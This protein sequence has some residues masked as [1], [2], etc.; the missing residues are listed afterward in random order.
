MKVLTVIGARP[1]IIKA[2]SLSREISLTPG[3]EEIIVHTGQ[4][5][6]K[7][8]SHIFF[9]QMQI[10][11]PNYNL[12]INGLSHGAMTGRMM[13]KIEELLLNDRPD[14]VVVFGDTNST[15]AGALAASKLHIPVAHV[16]AGIRSFNK[17]MPEEINRICTDHCSTILFSPNLQGIENLKAEGLYD[18]E[19][20]ILTGDIMY[21]SSMHFLNYSQ[22]PAQ[23]L[24]KKY[25][26]ATI[27]R[28][29]NTDG[30]NKLKEIIDG[31]N[32]INKDI[33]IV[34]P[35]HP[36]TEKLIIHSGIKVE[37]QTMEPVG[38]LEMIHLLKN[39]SMVVTD[40]GGLQKEAYFFKKPCVTV[41]DQTEWVEL[42]EHGA[43]I[44]ADAKAAEIKEKA[45]S[46]L[47]KEIN[48]D[49]ELYG[50]GHS[51]RKIVAALL[52]LEK[53]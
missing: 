50:D 1:Q 2:A 28:A 32:Q 48:Y 11:K 39:C 49:M 23:E 8:M 36:R 34:M 20:V 53:S 26:L 16:E 9:D 37:F 22:A 10:P 5:F 46:M 31:L 33:P 6:D 15:L 18:K 14:A 19:K 51:A 25:I 43:N 44:L 42:V 35:I 40:S 41:R 12:A 47:Y 3:I 27:H 4:H 21:D 52:K 13:E 24:P 7:N 29:E 17:K 38:Y 30:V 45:L